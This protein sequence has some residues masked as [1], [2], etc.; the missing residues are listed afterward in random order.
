M[1]THFTGPLFHQIIVAKGGSL[2]ARGRLKQ[3]F[4]IQSGFGD[5]KLDRIPSRNSDIVSR[6]QELE[7]ELFNLLMFVRVGSVDG[8]G[9][10]SRHLVAE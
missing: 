4:V 5:A 1:M 7:K 6:R 9:T 3:D 2:V 10:L 8:E